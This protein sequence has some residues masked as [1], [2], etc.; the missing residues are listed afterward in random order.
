MNAG[1]FAP[2]TAEAP[3]GLLSGRDH[4]PGMMQGLS[5]KARRLVLKQ[6]MTACA[7]LRLNMSLP[8]LRDSL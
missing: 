6:A 5:V 4:C 2:V 8:S 7:L 3:P 1:M